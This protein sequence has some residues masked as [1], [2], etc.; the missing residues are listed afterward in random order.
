MSSGLLSYLPLTGLAL[1]DSV[2]PKAAQ[3]HSLEQL[4]TLLIGVQMFHVSPP[5]P[6]REAKPTELFSSE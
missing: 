3:F 2:G 6:L 5:L 4:G 1:W